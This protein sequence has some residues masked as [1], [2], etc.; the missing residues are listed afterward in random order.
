MSHWDSVTHYWM[1]HKGSQETNKKV[2][3]QHEN[4]TQWNLWDLLKST[5]THNGNL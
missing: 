4:E 2:M 3:G 1:G 5:H